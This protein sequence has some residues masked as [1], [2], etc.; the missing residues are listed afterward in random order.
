MRGKQ[1]QWEQACFQ[2]DLAQGFTM[3]RRMSEE[4]SLRFQQK[5]RHWRGLFLCLKC[6]R[7]VVYVHWFERNENFPLGDQIHYYF[8]F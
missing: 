4:T 6:L 3:G 7:D 1:A 8:L 5:G 2:I